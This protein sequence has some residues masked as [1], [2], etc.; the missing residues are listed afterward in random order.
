MRIKRTNRHQGDSN[1]GSDVNLFK[2]LVG[3]FVVWLISGQLL[4]KPGEF[5]L[6]LGWLWSRMCSVARIRV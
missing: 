1:K 3:F 6:G 5:R 2:K 4:A